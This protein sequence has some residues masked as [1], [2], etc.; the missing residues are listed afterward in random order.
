MLKKIF[1]AVLLVGFIGVLIWGGVNRTLAKSG[2]STSDAQS[3]GNGHGHN[4]EALDLEGH[5]HDH[6]DA[7]LGQGGR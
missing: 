3:N 4:G 2:E 6:S 7:N 5:E 1:I